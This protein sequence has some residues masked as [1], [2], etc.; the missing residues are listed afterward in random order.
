MFGLDISYVH[1]ELVHLVWVTIGVVLLLGWLELRGRDAL[2]RFV[3]TVMQRR[4]A[5]RPSTGRILA[6]LALILAALLAGVWGL[7]QPQTSGVPETVSSTKVSA[8]IMVVL[9]VSKS[10][11]TADAMPDRLERANAEID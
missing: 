2:N 1:P 9:D 6:R 5:E 3:S 8:D 10:M 4:L 11:L 7:R